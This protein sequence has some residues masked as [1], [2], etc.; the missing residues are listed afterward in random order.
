MPSF[1]PMSDSPFKVEPPSAD[2]ERFAA[3]VN[4]RLR[5][6]RASVVACREVAGTRDAETTT[7]VLEVSSGP[8][9]H[10][11]RAAYAFTDEDEIV[12]AVLG[13]ID[14]KRHVHNETAQ[15]AA[16]D[17]FYRE[18]AILDRTPEDWSDV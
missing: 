5:P 14:A 3:S 4:T 16:G 17:E 12:K 6:H 1:F 9:R 8:Y 10:T 18:L 13:W 11:M 7:H 2:E 15:D